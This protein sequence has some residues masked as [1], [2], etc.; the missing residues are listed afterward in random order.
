MEKKK[1]IVNNKD[2]GEKMEKKKEVSF[3]ISDKKIIRAW[4]DAAAA[5]KVFDEKM[6]RLNELKVSV[7]RRVFS[8]SMDRLRLEK[9][10][11]DKEIVDV[12]LRFL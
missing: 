1:I 10:I 11:G 6:N 9:K 4:D 3:G 5:A 12:M 8:N 2:V 7:G